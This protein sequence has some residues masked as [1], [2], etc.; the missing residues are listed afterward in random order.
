MRGYRDPPGLPDE[1]PIGLD[2]F[3]TRRYFLL[4]GIFWAVV[5]ISYIYSMLIFS[6]ESIN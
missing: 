1:V 4:H 6:E 3:Q 2:F 5:C